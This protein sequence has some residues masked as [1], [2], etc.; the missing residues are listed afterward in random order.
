[1]VQS[2]EDIEQLQEWSKGSWK[3]W[4]VVL[5][6][7]IVSPFVCDP[8]DPFML[9]RRWLAMMVCGIT[10]GKMLAYAFMKFDSYFPGN[11]MKT[12]GDH[13]YAVAMVSCTVIWTVGYIISCV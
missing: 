9:V 2:Q 12:I 7:L 8:K 10:A 5:A 11:I 1:M 13:P 6:M 4:T 3:L